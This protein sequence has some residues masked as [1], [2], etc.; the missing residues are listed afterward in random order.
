MGPS[1][2]AF[3]RVA[4]AAI[5]LALL[6]RPQWR[7]EIRQNLTA[8]L[9]FG[10]VLSLMNFLFYQAI[11]RIPVGIAVALEFTGPLGLS[12]LKSRRWLEAVWV[13]IAA[14]GVALLAPVGGFELD[15]LGI[16]FALSAGVCWASYILLAARVGQLLPGVEGLTWAMLFGSLLLLPMGGASILPAFQQPQLLLTALG[17][18]L[19]SSVL[20]YTLELTALRYVPVQV[21]GVLMSLE[22]MVAA[23]AGWAILGETL[24]F[25]AIVAIV[26]IS[27]AAAGASRYRNI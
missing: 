25:R 1:G 23:I 21:F 4:L 7:P 8:V 19:L 27:A 9:M 17:V 2:M 22:P 12:V 18:A 11:A 16:V 24:T 26:L 6:W 5:I 15:W 10:A 14:A 3:F 20:P 13:A